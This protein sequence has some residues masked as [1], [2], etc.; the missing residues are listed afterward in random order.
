MWLGSYKE[1]NDNR[2]VTTV[3]DILK[4]IFRQINI[5]GNYNNL[6]GSARIAMKYYKIKMGKIKKKKRKTPVLSI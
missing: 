3:N 4:P 2:E 1:M 5:F 6:A